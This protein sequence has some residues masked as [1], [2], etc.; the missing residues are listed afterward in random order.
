MDLYPLLITILVTH[1]SFEQ[2]ITLPRH[3]SVEDALDRLRL[4]HDTRGQY[5]LSFDGVWLGES[6]SM[7]DVRMYSRLL[8][9]R[10][11]ETDMSPD[12]DRPGNG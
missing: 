1:P 7:R 6:T 10:L 5:H 4:P 11:I 3:A 12:A 8:G 9:F 2:H